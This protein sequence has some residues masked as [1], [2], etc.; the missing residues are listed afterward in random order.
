VRL[1]FDIGIGYLS[2]AWSALIGFACVPIFVHVLGIE[3]YGLIGFFAST[4][5]VL[6]LL[7]MGL[8]TTINREVARAAASG[9]P[10][11]AANLV[12]SVGM[13]YWSSALVIGL[14]MCLL[15][16][17]IAAH[18]LQS[19]ALAPSTVERAVMLMG[20]VIACRW[21]IGLYGGVLLG[22][23][24]FGIASGISML[25]VTLA[26]VGAIAALNLVSASVETYFV[27]QAAVGL[28]H[29]LVV[30]SAAWRTLAVNARPQFD[31]AALRRIGRFAVG[32]TGIAVSGVLLTQTDK[33]I[34][35]RML[36]LADFGRYAVAGVVASGLYLLLTPTFNIIYPRMSALIARGDEVG[37][38]NFYRTG[39]RLLSA[40]L[41]PVAATAIVYAQELLMV[42]TRDPTL[43]ASA[44]TITAMVLVGTA[45]NGA[46]HFPYA[47]Q[48]AAG[49]T[50]LP[51]TIYPA[52][53]VVMVPL[54]VVLASAYGALGGAMAWALLN[55][56]YL[57]L[58]TWLTHRSLLPGL[59]MRWLATD[60][61]LP[62]GLAA[63]TIGAVGAQIKSVALGSEW[64]L[65]LG[66][67]VAL[68]CS[69]ALLL[70]TQN[71][72]SAMRSIW[73]ATN[74]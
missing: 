32:M 53:I 71:T 58:G 61:L 67:L 31:A 48:L 44:S 8:A 14:S 12:H 11:G 10:E 74:P 30:R 37:L 2:A 6:L 66:A 64:T 20:V 49:A 34:L 18:W 63:V 59:G 36:P 65:A 57:L 28:L 46:M 24:R 26:N 69:T 62:A 70:M 56:L 29:A 13:I 5:A 51:L 55:V 38:V 4:Q 19:Q 3:S 41:F 7:D 60:V 68:A 72:R 33:L 39:S 73:F 54:T 9:R 45:L 21:P 50:R 25:M 27:W 52:L 42:W 23:Q 17:P 43:A 47:L 35:S 15:A 16:R 22:A 40:V 1:R